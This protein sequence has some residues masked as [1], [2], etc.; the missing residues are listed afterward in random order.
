M[1]SLKVIDEGMY[2]L[3]LYKGQLTVGSILVLDNCTVY[4]TLPIGKV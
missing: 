4:F 3:V 1:S 2:D